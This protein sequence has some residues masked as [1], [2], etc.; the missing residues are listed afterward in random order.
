MC[1]HAYMYA[2]SKT[3]E[4]EKKIT[5]KGQWLHLHYYYLEL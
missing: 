1:S 5:P 4:G 3:T 2:Y